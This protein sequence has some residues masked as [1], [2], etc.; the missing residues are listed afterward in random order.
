[1]I[2]IVT[3][4][5]FVTEK[6][7]FVFDFGGIILFYLLGGFFTKHSRTVSYFVFLILFRSILPLIKIILIKIQFVHFISLNITILFC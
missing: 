7:G 2:D 4:R 5:C 6:S 1:M 3:T